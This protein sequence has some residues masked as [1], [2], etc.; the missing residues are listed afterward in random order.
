[1]NYGPMS[2][3]ERALRS[4]DENNNKIYVKNFFYDLF[5]YYLRVG[6]DHFPNRFS[7]GRVKLTP[8]LLYRC[9]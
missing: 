1:M 8:L 2:T 5:T 4:I 3:I 7:S 6:I 9:R